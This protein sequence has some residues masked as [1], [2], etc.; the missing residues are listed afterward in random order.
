MRPFD[1]LLF[2]GWWHQFPVAW[3][4]ALGSNSLHLKYTHRPAADSACY[5]TVPCLWLFCLPMLADAI[6]HQICDS[7][8]GFLTAFFIRDMLD[9]NIQ[10]VG[11]C[12][13][14][15]KE[16]TSLVVITK[17]MKFI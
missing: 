11:R 2:S 13:S 12:P 7:A 16:R 5:T 6:V 8:R 3:T 15:K 10:M 17:Q 14:Y 9:D 1:G 4:W